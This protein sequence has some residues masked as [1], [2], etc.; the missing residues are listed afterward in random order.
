[1]SILDGE[2]AETRKGGAGEDRAT[3]AVMIVGYIEQ[4]VPC[5]DGGQLAATGN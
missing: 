1:V 3:V 2:A 5:A 4:V